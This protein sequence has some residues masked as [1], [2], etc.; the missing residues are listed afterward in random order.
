LND[1]KKPLTLANDAS[2]Y[3]LV[4]QSRTLTDAERRY[5]HIEKEMY[6]QYKVWKSFISIPMAVM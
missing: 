1:I 3:G 4:V 5:A 6:H 2:E